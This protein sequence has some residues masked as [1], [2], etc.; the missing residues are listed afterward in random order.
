M[1]STT[2]M[3]DSL[4]IYDASMQLPEPNDK[5]GILAWLGFNEIVSE[6]VL[7]EYEDCI[8]DND[9]EGI[10]RPSVIPEETLPRN[11]KRVFTQFDEEDDEESP[12]LRPEFALLCGKT[13]VHASEGMKERWYIKAVGNHVEDLVGMYTAMLGDLWRERAYAR[14]MESEKGTEMKTEKETW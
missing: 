8:K 12:G 4:A 1:G 7:K 13:P 9:P 2:Q 5:E 3:V 14:T 11:L 6:K 10:L